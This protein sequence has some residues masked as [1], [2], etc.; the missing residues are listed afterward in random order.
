MKM[1]YNE[2]ILQLLKEYNLP[3][4]LSFSCEVPKEIQEIVDGEVLKTIRGI[5]LKSL[6]NEL[7][8]PIREMGETPSTIEYDENH[9]HVDQY[10]CDEQ[11]AF[12]LGIKTL[13]LLAHKF[14]QQ[15]IAGVRFL[16]SFQPPSLGIKEA[17]DMHL[18]NEGDEYFI[19]DR[20]SFHL[21]RENEEV[22]A[23]DL[24]ESPYCAYLIIDV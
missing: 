10:A 12:K 22:V 9:F 3:T 11:Q 4:D 15:K 5:T 24:I 8:E 17:K 14:E 13:V 23:T 16:Y 1:N 7:R 19:S 2:V 18:H 6:S 21:K 20:L